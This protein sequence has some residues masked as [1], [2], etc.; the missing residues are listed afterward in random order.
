MVHDLVFQIVL[1]AFP[2]KLWTIEG[3]KSNLSVLLVR[4]SMKIFSKHGSDFIEIT[5][6]FVFLKTIRPPPRLVRSLRKRL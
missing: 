6:I 5:V 1:K 3:E 2:V 4:N